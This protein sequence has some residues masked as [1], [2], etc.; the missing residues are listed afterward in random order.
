MLTSF[1]S[2]LAHPYNSMHQVD[3][4][5]V[6]P[7]N[8]REPALNPKPVY[9]YNNGKRP[10]AVLHREFE[11]NPYGNK[12][13]WES[14][15]AGALAKDIK[16]PDRLQEYRYVVNGDG[17][18]RKWTYDIP[19]SEL[20]PEQITPDT[21][22]QFSPLPKPPL[23]RQRV[24]QVL[25]GRQNHAI[26]SS[27]RSI[28]PAGAFHDTVIDSRTGQE[29]D[30][31]GVGKASHSEVQCPLGLYMCRDSSCVAHLSYCPGCDAV[32]MPAFCTLNPPQPSGWKPSLIGCA[33]KAKCGAHVGGG[34]FLPGEAVTDGG[35]LGGLA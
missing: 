30:V 8:M 4:K 34:L 5:F 17:E 16:R 18:V 29:L 24:A 21:I 1:R 26:Q 11:H 3:D 15:P 35:V 28:L 27:F 12:L 25:I 14:G 6:N 32:P 33:D 31:P 10:K 19:K 23:S 2:D 20:R 9:P 22:E 13:P 7:Y